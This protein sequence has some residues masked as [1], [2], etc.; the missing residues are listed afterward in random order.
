MGDDEAP[1]AA[2]DPP[3]PPAAVRVEVDVIVAVHNASSTLRGAVASALGQRRGRE[4]DGG[5]LPPSWPAAGERGDD[6]AP[7]PPPTTGRRRRCRLEIAVHVCCYDDGSSDGSRELLRRIAEE[8]RGE[9]ARGG[10]GGEEEGIAGGAAQERDEDRTAPAPAPALASRQEASVAPA[11][12]DKELAVVASLAVRGRTDVR[13]SGP[14]GPGGM[15][16][17]THLHVAASPDGAS[18]GAGYARNRAVEMRPALWR[19][20]Q[21]EVRNRPGGG[22]DDEDETHHHQFLCLLDSD[23]VM[24]EDRVWTQVRHLLSL[25]PRDRDRCVLGCGFARDPPDSTWHYAR[26][27]NSLPEER[28]GLERY[29]EVTVVQPTWVRRLHGK[30]PAPAAARS[31]PSLSFFLL[32]FSR[33]LL[34]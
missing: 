19:R 24:S 13:A 34:L 2:A 21:S 15:L 12:S 5:G 1:A 23:D 6:G 11:A 22:E 10:A 30:M 33:C 7:P 31:S 3:P 26:W 14:G 4:D 8:H 25:S 32:L 17:E 18:R 27:A 9:V 20:R 29:R 28:L 16:L